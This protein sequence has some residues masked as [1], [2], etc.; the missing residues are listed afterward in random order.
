[1]KT[2]EKT[3]RRTM[4]MRLTTFLLALA[5]LLV[6]LHAAM[7]QNQFSTVI[8]VNDSSITGF[9]LDQRIRFLELL[10]FPGDIRA[11]AEKGLIEDRLRLAVAR[12][13]G[14][15]LADEQIAN[16][17]AEFASRANLDTEQFL[18][19]IGQGGVEP[20]TFRDFVEAGLAWREMV[21]AR[22]G[23]TVSVSEAE[24]DRAISADNGRGDG[25]RVLLSEIILRARAG[26]VGRVRRI[27]EQIAA[28]ATSESAF[29]EMARTRSL[30]ASR[31][32]GGRVDWI[33]LS[34]LPPQ[35]QAAIGKLGQ[36]QISEPVPLQGFIGLFLLRGFQGGPDQ[37]QGTVVVDFAQVALPAGASAEAAR[38]RAAAQTCNDLYALVPGGQVQ[39]NRLPRGQV[40]GAVL[41]ELDRLDPNETSANLRGQSGGVTFLMLC[42]RNAT[43]AANHIDLAVPV[44]VNPAPRTGDGDIIP[45]VIDGLGFGFGAPRAQVRE[46]LVNRKLALAAEAWLAELKAGAIITYP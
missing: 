30:S 37:P 41:A 10:E 40:P 43:I 11:E 1:M 34:N 14:F 3:S 44:A 18:A 15:R 28:E 16:G 23:A 25:P 42:E 32:D 2:M 39:R 38:L 13:V 20:E 27:A 19:A 46:E 29:A 4:R 9:E 17:M 8:R 45:S 24:I 26:E 33:P 35:A 31:A 6:S 12:S 22:F 21:R 5:T 7:A 36:G